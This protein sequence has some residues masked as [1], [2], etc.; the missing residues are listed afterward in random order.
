MYKQTVM[1]FSEHATTGS[2][3]RSVH[4]V[5]LTPSESRMW[6]RQQPP[7]ATGASDR[8]INEK[9][10][11]KE[12]RIVTE[13]NREKLPNFVDALRRPGYMELR[14][15]Y[16]RRPRWDAARQSRLIESFI[17]NIPV[18]PVF[19]YEQAYNSYEVMDGQQRISAIQAFYENR[20]TLKG[21]ELWPELNGRTYA[22]LPSKIKAGIDRRSISSIVLVKESA[23]SEEEAMLI[24]RLVFERLNTGGVKLGRQEIR[25]SLY[26]GPLNTLTVNLSRHPLFAHTLGLPDVVEEEGKEIPAALLDN[27]MYTTM[28]DVELVLRFFALRH[29]KH[30][31]DGIQGFLDLYLIHGRS[32][33][34]NDLEELKRLFID[35]LI[36]GYKI[37]DSLL[38]KPYDTK[39]KKWTKRVQAAF[40]DAVM[41]G[42]CQYLDRGDLLIE[43]RERVIDETK[44]L[45]EKHP[46]GTFT[47]RKSTKADIEERMRLFQ[48]MLHSIL[49]EK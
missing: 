41:V 19:L 31:R 33:N 46:V 13:S 43:K 2:E 23:D 11:S 4:M 49:E 32:F 14:P 5:R 25:N 1:S 47:G 29:M 26:Q 42:L 40:Y 16:Q 10:D 44:V 36:L 6:E 15:F 20:L 35:T 24:K 37:Y 45:F 21:L 18:P 30:F 3:I 12:Q 27:T 28:E 7:K 9:Y 38:F 8:E 34:T 48:E 17:I 22:T 39:T